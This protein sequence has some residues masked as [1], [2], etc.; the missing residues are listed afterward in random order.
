VEA[1]GK[2]L[3]LVAVPFTNEGMAAHPAFAES[4]DK[5]RRWGV[6]V[7]WGPGVVPAFPPGDG[8]GYVDAF[9]WNLAV[10]EIRLRL[11]PE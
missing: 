4:I 10:Q 1:L 8:D 3:P 2:G 7:L 9:P 5:L 6:T 11:Y